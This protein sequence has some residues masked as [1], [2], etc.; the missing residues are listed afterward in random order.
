MADF[1]QPTENPRL[2]ITM[3]TLPETG[4]WTV[5]A[6]MVRGMMISVQVELTKIMKLLWAGFRIME[7]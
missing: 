7:T 3:Q 6:D 4:I 1:H 5:M 2:I